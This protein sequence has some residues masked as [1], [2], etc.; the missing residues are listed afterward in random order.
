[1]V[2]ASTLVADRPLTALALMRGVSGAFK[3]TSENGRTVSSLR[4]LLHRYNQRTALHSP[5]R[6]RPRWGHH[7][8]GTVYIHMIGTFFD[9]LKNNSHDFGLFNKAGKLLTSLQ[10]RRHS[11]AR[12]PKSNTICTIFLRRRGVLHPH[13]IQPT[14]P[15]PSMSSPWI[16]SIFLTSVRNVF[17]VS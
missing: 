12:S 17:C 8:F 15:S 14:R 9:A 10:R 3:H 1:M 6:L 13:D 11:K 7:R 2:Y 16:S 4:L 5:S